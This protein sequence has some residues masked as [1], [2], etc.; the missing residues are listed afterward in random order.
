MKQICR[1]LVLVLPLAF[2]LIACAENDRPPEQAGSLKKAFHSLR[3][4]LDDAIPIVASNLKYKL[5]ND[6]RV[7]DCLIEPGKQFKSRGYYI[8]AD[9]GQTTELAFERT[10]TYFEDRGYQVTRVGNR[11]VE[12]RK[13]DEFAEYA[14]SVTVPGLLLFDGE[15]DC[16]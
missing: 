2:A 11:R 6:E 14:L 15:T 3:I 10:T 16:L 13:P 1:L 4:K 8:Y 5:V 7:L 12:M 9:P